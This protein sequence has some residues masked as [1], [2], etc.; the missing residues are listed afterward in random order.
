MSR[1]LWLL[2]HGKSD[3]D[4]LSIED[5]DRPL[6]KRGKLAAQ[7]LGEGMH[8]QHLVPDWIVSS[9]AK[10]ALATAKIVH[11]ALAIDGLLIVKDRRLYQE[12]FERLKTVLAECPLTA[13]RVLLVGHNP[14]LEDLLGYLVGTN[15]LPDIDKLLPTAALARLLLP[16][17]WSHLVAG[18]AKLLRITYA[19]SLPEDTGE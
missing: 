6:K 5:F 7:H 2:R 4:N 13:E 12:G 10:R 17:D 11:K 9:P 8:Q 16:D 15:H 14:E 1:E 3:R 19:K 18:S